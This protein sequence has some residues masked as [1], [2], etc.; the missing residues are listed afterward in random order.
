LLDYWNVWLDGKYAAAHGSAYV[1]ASRRL[2]AE[3]S[4]IVRSI[5]KWSGGY[6]VDLQTA[7][8]GPDHA[9]DATHLL[10][11]DGD[12][13]NAAGHARISKAIE[14]TIASHA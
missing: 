2:T 3:V 10:A 7:F 13:P 8:R 1:H 11:P 14:H 9:W 4:A 5:A 6:W 12:H